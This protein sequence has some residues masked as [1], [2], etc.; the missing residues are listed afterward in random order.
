MIPVVGTRMD[1][2][3]GTRMGS[4]GHQ[5]ALLRNMTGNY[6]HLHPL[7]GPTA[8]PW[9]GSGWGSTVYRSVSCPAPCLGWEYPAGSALAIKLQAWVA[10]PG[11]AGS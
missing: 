3:V 9:T 6:A 10:R 1:S 5:V 7:S 2:A 4:D 8:G 11:R